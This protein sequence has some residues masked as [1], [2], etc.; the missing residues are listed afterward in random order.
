MSCAC[1]RKSAALEHCS[2]GTFITAIAA[3]RQNQSII[4]SLTPAARR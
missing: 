1:T 2:S 4:R 3:K